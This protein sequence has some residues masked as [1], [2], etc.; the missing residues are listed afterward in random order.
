M[1][2]GALLIEHPQHDDEHLH[3]HVYD[4]EYQGHRIEIRIYNAST[5][6]YVRAEIP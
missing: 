3:V 2:V 1:P 5:G 6:I 4:P